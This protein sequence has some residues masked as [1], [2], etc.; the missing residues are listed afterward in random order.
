MGR[1]RTALSPMPWFV[2]I[3]IVAVVALIIAGAI[4]ASKLAKARR[5]ALST[6]A[7]GRGWRFDPER[8]PAPRLEDRFARFSRGRKH[9]VYNTVEGRTTLGPFDCEIQ[10]G[11]YRYET[12]STD[13][14][15]NSSTQVHRLS[16]LLVDLGDR[17]MPS[18]QIRKEGMFDKMKAAFGFE[19]ID[20]ESEEFSR[21]Y[22]VT[23]SDKRFAYDLFH[24]RMIEL[25]LDGRAPELEIAD[26]RVCFTNGSRVWA[27]EQFDSEI[28]RARRFIDLWPPHLLGTKA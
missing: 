18:V 26:G 17:S 16:Y 3:I 23:S 24:P 22:Y 11:D 4:H 9:E 10:T 27:P 28:E 7:A 25:F 15:G 12:E 1:P 2:P 5:E 19:D 20:F 6:W 14:D 21:K 13:G 8:R